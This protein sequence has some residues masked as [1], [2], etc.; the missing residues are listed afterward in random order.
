MAF[1]GGGDSLVLLLGAK[2]WADRRGRRLAAV[3]VDHRLRPAGADWAR[4]CKAR[5]LALGV[6]HDI[7]TWEGAKPTTGLAAAARGARHVLLAEAARRRGAAVILMGHTADDRREAAAMRALGATTPSPREWAPSPV[8]PQGRGLFVLRPLLAIGR[9]RLRAVLTSLGETW[10]DDPANV[11]QRSLRARVRAAPDASASEDSAP[12]D[13]AP[14]A[15]DAAG[16][17][18]GP[19]GDLTMSARCCRA[20]D[21]A[22]AT[23]GAALLCAA[24]AARVPRRRSL[25][26][27]L[28]AAAAGRPF[29]AGLAGARVVGG[30]GGLHL[31]REVGAARPRDHA[32]MVLSP[33]AADVWDGRFEVIAREEGARIS[34]LAGRAARLP[35]TLRAAVL[36]TPAAIRPALPLVTYADGTVACPTL[37]H[38]RR[39]QVVSLALPRLLAARGGI[40]DEA[41]LRRM[42]KPPGPS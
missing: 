26:R 22:A 31:V 17:Q 33:G 20:A 5:A 2:A 42:A 29:I 3:T 9:T 4:W 13:A 14:A 40:L 21:G 24:G 32:D 7:V 25:D 41:T 19:A 23:L 28:T 18:E 30:D 36:R 8:W 38:S 1:S 16:I 39:I 34:F 11:D 27:L 35:P 6:E 15:F 37:A 12:D 10:I